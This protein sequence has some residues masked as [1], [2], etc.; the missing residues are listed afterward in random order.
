MRRPGHHPKYKGIDKGK[1]N[2]NKRY[3]PG[4][5]I[6]PE[7]KAYPIKPQQTDEKPGEEERLARCDDE[8]IKRVQTK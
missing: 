1:S 8:K 5:T 2:G 7:A 4:K 6:V 3:S